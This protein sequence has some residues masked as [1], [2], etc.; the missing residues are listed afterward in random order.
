MS[1]GK[2]LKRAYFT[3]YPPTAGY[4]SLVQPYCFPITIFHDLYNT[5]SPDN[6]VYR[7]VLP[8]LR[9]VDTV[10]TTANA[11]EKM[12]SPRV[13]AIILGLAVHRLVFIHGEWHLRGPNVVVCHVLLAILLYAT[14]LAFKQKGSQ[15][16]SLQPTQVIV[17]Y[18]SSLF[19]SIAVYRIF[20]HRLKH[21]PGPRLAALTKLWHVWKCRDSRG[22]HVLQAWHEEYGEFVRT[23]KRIIPVMLYNKIEHSNPQV[24]AKSPSS[25]PKRTRPW[26]ASIIGIHGPIGMTCFIREYHLSSLG[27]ESFITNGGR[28]GSRL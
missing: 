8:A 10:S 27:T 15:Y 21:L 2:Q 20:F 13:F 11:L 12:L 22:H 25:T 17:C 16:S 19:S 3:G 4:Y 18:L 28:Y 5:K 26:T 9:V 14:E 7:I 6:N 23:G 24:P 1:G